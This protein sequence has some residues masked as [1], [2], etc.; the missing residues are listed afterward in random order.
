MQSTYSTKQTQQVYRLPTCFA[1]VAASPTI[2]NVDIET[3]GTAP[4]ALKQQHLIRTVH[5]LMSDSQSGTSCS[6]ASLL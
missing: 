5:Y 3:Y 2:C 4:S 6:E 1:T